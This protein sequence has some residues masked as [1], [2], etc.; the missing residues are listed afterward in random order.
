VRPPDLNV[1]KEPDLQER[2]ARDDLAAVETEKSAVETIADRLLD[3]RC[4]PKKLDPF[5]HK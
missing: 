3:D 4:A 1:V 2:L 5:P